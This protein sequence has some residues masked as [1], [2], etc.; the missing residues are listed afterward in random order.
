[1]ISQKLLGL[2]DMICY[3]EDERLGEFK[4]YVHNKTDFP[5]ESTDVHGVY[6]I[7]TP[8]PDNEISKL[9][10]APTMTEMNSNTLSWLKLRKTE[11]C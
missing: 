1:M 9:V 3:L 8:H 6:P 10:G 11:V 4:S 5:M 2:I 7:D